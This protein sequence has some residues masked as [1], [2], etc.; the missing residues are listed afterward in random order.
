MSAKNSAVNSSPLHQSFFNAME[1]LIAAKVDAP[2]AI[3]C[4]GGADS[5]ACILLAQEWAHA[6]SIK[7][8]ALIIDH[9]L[10]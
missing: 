9:G 6:Q 8:V 10:R 4:S 2:L 7:I 3:A 1:Q 5:M